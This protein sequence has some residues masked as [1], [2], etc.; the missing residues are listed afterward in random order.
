MIIG[1]LRWG[2]VEVI[3]QVR[4]EVILHHLLRQSL[5]VTLSDSLSLYSLSSQ[6]EPNAPLAPRGA[7]PPHLEV[8]PHVLFAPDKNSNPRKPKVTGR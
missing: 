2:W 3:L 4:L 8:P 7:V 1:V 5:A 6:A